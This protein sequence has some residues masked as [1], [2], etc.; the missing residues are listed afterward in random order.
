MTFKHEVGSCYPTG[1]YRSWLY[2]GGCV[3]VLASTCFRVLQHTTDSCCDVFVLSTTAPVMRPMLHRKCEQGM[4]A[5]PTICIDRY[6]MRGAHAGHGV[7]TYRWGCASIV[8]P[9]AH[10]NT[11][12]WRRRWRYR[13]G[14]ARAPAACSCNEAKEKNWWQWHHSQTTPSQTP[15]FCGLETR[16]RR[17]KKEGGRRARRPSRPAGKQNL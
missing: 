17:P 13:S 3:E 1:P 7:R 15:V 9:G 4:P 2:E 5:R 8:F 12:A 10:N 16:G 11:A 6:N 14:G